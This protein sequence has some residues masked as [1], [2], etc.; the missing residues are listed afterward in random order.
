MP[1]ARRYICSFC[2]KSFSRSEHKS[3]HERSHTNE[4]PFSCSICFSKFVRRDLLQRHLRTVHNESNTSKL[5]N[6]IPSSNAS[7]SPTPVHSDS[8]SPN[9]QINQSGGV[10]SHGNN[11]DNNNSSLQDV[12][13]TS[14]K[15]RISATPHNDFSE[16]GYNENESRLSISSTHKENNQ[17]DLPFNISSTDTS[18]IILLSENATENAG[19]VV[20][21]VKQDESDNNP[22]GGGEPLLLV[23]VLTLLNIAN[24]NRKEQNSPSLLS[25]TVSSSSSESMVSVPLAK[26]HSPAIA[27]DLETQTMTSQENIKQ[28]HGSGIF[29]LSE[30]TSKGTSDPVSTPNRRGSLSGPAKDEPLSSS[31]IVSS[32]FYSLSERN[33]ILL[34]TLAKKFSKLDLRNGVLVDSSTLPPPPIKPLVANS[35]ISNYLISWG[36]VS[37]MKFPIVLNLNK[38]LNLTANPLFS[39]SSTSNKS[40][41]TKS[42]NNSVFNSALFHAILSFGAAESG[43]FHDCISFYKTCWNLITRRLLQPEEVIEPL[44]VLAFI[45]LNFMQELHFIDQCSVVSI[46]KVFQTLNECIYLLISNKF[47]HNPLTAKNPLHGSISMSALNYY[48]SHALPVPPE[49]LSLEATSRNLNSYVESEL[50]NYWYIYSILSSYTL[51]FNTP[52]PKIHVLFLNKILPTNNDYHLMSTETKIKSI[53][54]QG[55]KVIDINKRIDFL[56]NETLKDALTGLCKSPSLLK[57]MV[58]LNHTDSMN[59]LSGAIFPNSTFKNLTLRESCIIFGLSNELQSLICNESTNLFPNKNVMHNAIIISNK[60]LNTNSNF[61]RFTLDNQGTSCMPSPSNIDKTLQ[62]KNTEFSLFQNVPY[63]SHVAT[64]AT[65]SHTHNVSSFGSRSHGVHSPN[66]PNLNIVNR[67]SF[68]SN[69][70][71]MFNINNF[72]NMIVNNNINQDLINMY[73][74]IILLK[75]RVLVNCDKKLIQDLL[76]DYII[77][78]N[79]ETYWNLLYITIKEFVFTNSGFIS[80]NDKSNETNDILAVDAHNSGKSKNK[81]IHMSLFT[82]FIFD[83]LKGFD[84]NL[85]VRRLVQF[86]SEKNQKHKIV[87]NNN[88]GLTSLPILFIGYLIYSS[89]SCLDKSGVD[90]D[91]D[92][93]SRFIAINSSTIPYSNLIF[94][95]YFLKLPKN[96]VNLLVETFLVLIK[97]FYGFRKEVAIIY[98]NNIEKNN[99]EAETE[100]SMK[101]QKVKRINPDVEN[102]INS[103]ITQSIFYLINEMGIDLNDDPYIMKIITQHQNNGLENGGDDSKNSISITEDL[104]K[105]ENLLDAEILD[106]LALYF[107]LRSMEILFITWIKFIDI[108]KDHHLQTSSSYPSSDNSLLQN[109]VTNIELTMSEIYKTLNLCQPNSNININD[110]RMN[111]TRHGYHVHNKHNGMQNAYRNTESMNFQ[112]LPNQHHFSTFQP[113]M[114]NN[115]NNLIKQPNHGRDLNYHPLNYSGMPMNNYYPAEKQHSTPFHSGVSTFNNSPYLPNSGPMYGNS[116]KG[117]SNVNASLLHHEKYPTSLNEFPTTHDTSSF[118]RMDMLSSNNS[119]GMNGSHDV[120]NARVVPGINIGNS[121][122]RT[123]ANAPFYQPLQKNIIQKTANVK[124]LISNLINDE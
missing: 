98:N 50:F 6:I 26:S 42:Q 96:F 111:S 23:L 88:L 97:I 100:N 64:N 117:N 72:S 120:Q 11:N 104:F 73:N 18:K 7:S 27:G 70:S 86:V 3:R 106:D 69:S 60:S 80:S 31:T 45:S 48:K 107:Y 33:L 57:N 78:P 103:P 59:S 37:N 17:K 113:A 55:N 105:P 20:V 1:P 112:N 90:M 122:S 34:L 123:G 95:R 110:I 66:E 52:P 54:K 32:N 16:N 65:A 29:Q 87:V 118:T 39:Q 75:K 84:C 40:S 115:D 13:M 8:N 79:H 68:N 2:A 62:N 74:Y 30:T 35:K 114:V 92:M 47:V 77:I 109:L 53:N 49:I 21:Q 101:R 61:Q 63:S 67:T 14:Q 41:Y 83:V 5:I 124:N 89:Q 15:S 46:H 25:K 108:G 43:Q 51:Y 10:V 22:G 36:T 58:A 56:S 24:M 19:L 12:C 71:Y 121:D 91:H 82:A 99:T 4:K 81:E 28:D 38:L 102:I 93:L 9:N 119:N 94:L 76:I 44:T 116:Y 85:T